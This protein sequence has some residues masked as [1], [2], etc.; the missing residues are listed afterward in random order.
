MRKFLTA[1]L[2]L[3]LFF[4]AGLRADLTAQST[5]AAA[6]DNKP[7]DDSV[8]SES[9][10]FNLPFITTGGSQFWTDH[11]WRD[12]H[13]IQKN[14]LT[15]HWRLLDGQNVRRAWGTKEQCITA[16]N[17]RCPKSDPA[18]Q[19]APKHYV[20][21]LH[22]LMRTS[23][24]MKGLEDNLA[25]N[26]FPNSIRFS[27][28]STRAS[29]GQHAAALREMIEELPPDATFSFVGHSMGNIVVR[30]LVGDLQAAGDPK[31]VL[32]RCEAM[33]MLGPPNQGAAIARRL[34]PTKVFGW[35]TGEGG[36][37]LGERWDE[38]EKHLACPPFPF[39]IIAG[40]LP[41]PVLNPLV[42]GQSDFIVSLDEA[43]LDGAT[44]FE[45]VPALHSF[46]MDDATSVEK[47]VAFL[48]EHAPDSATR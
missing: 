27:Y 23:G 44:G 35:V 26:G 32:P 33:V 43:R 2:A 45:T 6:S 42:D 10:N 12:G 38:F 25:Q 14:H 11:L 19:Q 17:Q 48:K 36:M 8:P 16:L 18:T 9:T 20:I 39:L 1:T 41:A 34:A 7:V 3:S 40:D 28:A 30:H 4:Q 21:L 47:T 22:G 24:S 37:Q 13:R 5:D 46:L 15:G 31:N 29:I